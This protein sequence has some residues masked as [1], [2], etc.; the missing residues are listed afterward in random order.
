MYDIPGCPGYHDPGTAIYRGTSNMICQ[1][2]IKSE[3]D[4]S[5]GHST[6]QKTWM[7]NLG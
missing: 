5:P 2:R 6:S 3:K 4:L 1:S 7:R